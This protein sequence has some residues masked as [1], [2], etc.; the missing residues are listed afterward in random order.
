[1]AETNIPQFPRVVTKIA[2]NV[3]ISEE[4][5]NRPLRKDRPKFRNLNEEE[6]EIYARFE[7]MSREERR[8]LSEADKRRFLELDEKAMGFDRWEGRW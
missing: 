3:P 4:Q 5:M 7:R 1:M 6:S 2:P 8:S